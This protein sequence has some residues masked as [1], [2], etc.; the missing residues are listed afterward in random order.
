MDYWALGV[1]AY[2]LLHGKRPFEKHCPREMISYLEK[3]SEAQQEINNKNLAYASSVGSSGVPWS[4]HQGSN[5]AV[6]AHSVGFGL[7]R[8]RLS[9]V[10][11]VNTSNPYLGS[12]QDLDYTRI[13]ASASGTDSTLSMS[14]SFINASCSVSNFNCSRIEHSGLPSSV[15]LPANALA[16]LAKRQ[17]AAAVQQQELA[18]QSGMF[19]N[20]SVA[21][22]ASFS[23]KQRGSPD[24]LVNPARGGSPTNITSG[25]AS[26]S[27]ST[28]NSSSKILAAR[29][30]A[31]LSTTQ[32]GCL[33]PQHSR[34]G[35]FSINSA[36]SGSPVATASA[37]ATPYGSHQ[38]SR[39]SS[40]DRAGQYINNGSGT[41]PPGCKTSSDDSTEKN[42]FSGSPQGQG[43]VKGQGQGK[44][45]GMFP[46]LP[47]PGAQAEYLAN[48]D[49]ALHSDAEGSVPAYIGSTN[50]S[51][52]ADIGSGS[53][54]VGHSVN[55]ADSDEGSMGVIPEN[56]EILAI[57][58]DN[59]SASG[60]ENIS[61]ISA[62]TA[63]TVA[64]FNTLEDEGNVAH[65]SWCGV[66]S[67]M[68]AIFG[69]HW[70]IES[71]PKLTKKN[72]LK[73][74]V[75]DYNVWLGNLSK[76]CVDC[77]ENLLEL[78]PSHRL[79]G[80]NIH[81]L[82]EHLWMQELGLTDW[83]NLKSKAPDCAPHFMP[84]K[85]YIQKKYGHAHPLATDAAA[86]AKLL[87][88]L[89]SKEDR[90]KQGNVIASKIHA[91]QEAQFAEFHY[92]SPAFDYLVSSPETVPSANGGS[93]GTLPPFVA[94]SSAVY[95]NPSP[96]GGTSH[97]L[98][99]SSPS[100]SSHANRDAAV[101]IIQSNGMRGQN[102]AASVAAYALLYPQQSIASQ[103]KRDAERD[104]PTGAGAGAVAT[105]NVGGAGG[106]NG[107]GSL[108]VAQGPGQGS[109]SLQ[110]LAANLK[111]SSLNN[112]NSFYTGY[113]P[114][115]RPSTGQ[116]GQGYGAQSYDSRQKSIDNDDETSFSISR[117][118]G[119]FSSGRGGEAGAIGGAGSGLFKS[120]GARVNVNG[121]ATNQGPSAGNFLPASCTGGPARKKFGK[122]SNSIVVAQRR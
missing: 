3:Q 71:N 105:A 29:T 9:P 69:N 16:A 14:G 114:Q 110:T 68:G 10:G 91:K 56:E 122:S 84:G 112:A 100:H 23:P 48:S 93:I 60:M 38:G 59:T 40:S 41:P 61:R 37:F 101:T 104:I 82:R 97:H 72:S 26:G 74:E 83:E 34:A 85:S 106:L 15:K 11:F 30:S 36:M 119:G 103:M 19:A 63:A 12:V 107:G 13:S 78:R 22:G 70:A 27:G 32:T 67:E 58:T 77:I 108:A 53:T 44:P 50:G 5:T 47:L 45:V 49:K 73:V 43:Q 17:A 28:E 31:G 76:S 54:P 88:N 94:G 25:M 33:S 120:N 87:K 4:L 2:E 121:L 109:S 21:S 57:P 18:S 55:A 89:S 79:G 20:G 99:N 52:L 98:L 118:H 115:I 75:P 42:S 92:G 6:V 46:P 111:K 81:V 113:A 64:A 24:M 51:W 65:T 86:H 7:P 102:A 39:V 116:Q 80:R 1:V 66:E 35:S 8:G 90:D 117:H 62:A 96:S 95:N